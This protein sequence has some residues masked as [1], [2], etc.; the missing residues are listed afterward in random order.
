MNFGVTKKIVT[1]PPE[2]LNSSVPSSLKRSAVGAPSTRSTSARFETKGSNPFHV[3]GR[4]GG[5]RLKR[6]DGLGEVARLRVGVAEQVEGLVGR[7]RRG[8]GAL[9]G[10]DGLRELLGEDERLALQQRGA[11]VVALAHE[12]V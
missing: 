3:V 9:K 4:L 8:G 5:G 11:R 2:T 10:G 7:L 1:R 12:R 6:G